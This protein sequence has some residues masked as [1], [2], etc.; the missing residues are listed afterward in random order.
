MSSGLARRLGT[1]RPVRGA[2]AGVEAFL[3]AGESGYALDLFAE[4]GYTLDGSTNV[5]PWVEQAA[6]VSFEQAV[7]GT[8]PAWLASGLCGRP[9]VSGAGDGLVAAALTIGGGVYS[10]YCWLDVVDATTLSQCLFDSQA[11]RLILNQTLLGEVNTG[12]YDGT[13]DRPIAAPTTGAQCLQ[14]YVNGGS[15]EMKRGG[16]S[17]GSSVMTPR[18]YGGAAGVLGNFAAS[19]GYATAKVGRFAIFTGVHDA[20]TQTRIRA[21]GVAHYPG[22]PA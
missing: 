20:A 6:A 22:M 11:G 18:S 1:R 9:A 3:L 2:G 8:R 7:A 4:A 10:I 5:S 19:G 21:K 14:W 12:I 13:G 15:F 16:T 17:L